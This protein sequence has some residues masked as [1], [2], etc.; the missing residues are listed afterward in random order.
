MEF[1]ERITIEEQKKLPSADQKDYLRYL[2]KLEGNEEEVKALDDSDFLL[3]TGGGVDPADNPGALPPRDL[4]KPLPNTQA[5]DDNID[6]PASMRGELGSL[7]EEN[8]IIPS[9]ETKPPEKAPPATEEEPPAEIP[10]VETAKETKEEPP[11]TEEE[12]P[13]EDKPYLQVNEQ[14]TYKTE[15]EARKGFDEKDRTIQN[16]TE[17]IRLAKQENELLVREAE[18]YKIRMEAEQRA[19]ELAA[20]PEV[21]VPETPT[22]EIPTP[23]SAD[24]LYAIW[25]DQEKGPI[26]AL[27]LMMPHAI[28][29]LG[30]QK[31]IDLAER[32]DH[33]KADELI[34]KWQTLGVTKIMEGFHDDFIY[35][36][37]DR[38]Y[39]E[40]EGKWRDPDDPIG[41]AYSKKFF[42]ID[43]SYKSI[44]GA[45][46]T[47]ISKR[48]PQALQ[49][50][51]GEV[52]ARTDAPSNNGDK[53]QVPATTGPPEVPSGPSHTDEADKGKPERRFTQAEA[54][55][56][57]KE[58]VDLAVNAVEERNALHSKTQ[59]ETGGAKVSQ[60][61]SPE[62]EWT[63][64]EI[65]KNP[66][67]WAKSRR[68]NPH[69]AKATLDMLPQV[70]E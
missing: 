1:T 57:A 15:E 62:I 40:F 45:T 8:P 38:K 5:V 31:L 63:K 28:Q 11:V 32:L 43:E 13:T 10:P 35:G 52:L 58:K 16:K 55:A 9:I 39:P 20:P 41:K 56:Y 27:K 51:I 6:L 2:F 18:S 69:F 48:S 64:A 47:E 61:V 21:E 33:L 44:H 60:P 17:E 34:Q 19:A 42:E 70:R 30:I 29:D 14:T 50:S 53:P 37:I 23:P 3:P 67:G 22:V 46:L 25:D 7:E 12:P 26:E 49:W 4:G 59:T 65:M 36:E 24:E 54:Q 66:T 68:S